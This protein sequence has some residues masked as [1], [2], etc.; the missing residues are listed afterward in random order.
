[1]AMRHQLWKFT[2]RFSC[3]LRRWS[4]SFQ[5]DDILVTVWE[6]L[7]FKQLDFQRWQKSKVN[8]FCSSVWWNVPN[9]HIPTPSHSACLHRNRS[10]MLHQTSVQEE[11]SSTQEGYFYKQEVYSPIRFTSTSSPG[12]GGTVW[13]RR[14]KQEA[15]SQDGQ[16][17]Q[18]MK[19]TRWPIY[20]LSSEFRGAVVLP[21]ELSWAE[22]RTK[23]RRVLRFVKD[24]AIIIVIT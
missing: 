11:G 9:H 12:L 1:M 6:C 19:N 5:K 7:G 24:M 16:A 23:I 3:K 2:D 8:L 15:H 13:S 10:G 22:H 18:H 17:S 14:R 21:S 20:L 4:S